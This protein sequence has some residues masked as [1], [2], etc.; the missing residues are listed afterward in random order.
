M[1]VAHNQAELDRVIRIAQKIKGVK[2]VIS[3]VKMIGEPI[4]S[5][6]SPNPAPTG[7]R[8]APPV[9]ITPYDAAPVMDQSVPAAPPPAGIESEVLPP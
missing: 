8:A 3:Y 4:A 9:P 1:G 2:E 6:R 5:S 7:A